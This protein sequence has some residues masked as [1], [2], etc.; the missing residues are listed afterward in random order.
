MANRE[1]PLPSSTHDNSLAR[2]ETDESGILRQIYIAVCRIYMEYKVSLIERGQVAFITRNVLH[3]CVGCMLRATAIKYSIEF[4]MR[5]NRN[6]S[7]TRGGTQLRLLKLTVL[8]SLEF[9]VSS[10]IAP[11]RSH[12]VV[13][14]H[15]M[16]FARVDN[17]HE[18]TFHT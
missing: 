8:S 2:D 6:V 4:R 11:V 16:N 13:R 18:I 12:L 15:T 9:L 10:S 1:Q 14:I 7:R 5:C 3:M 17:D